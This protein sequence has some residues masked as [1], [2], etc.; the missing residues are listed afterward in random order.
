MKDI[1][2]KKELEEII[3]KLENGIDKFIIAG[4]Y[5]GLN[6]SSNYKE[7]LLNLK[8]DC[9]DFE[10]ETINLPDGRIVKM[11]KLLKQ[12]T[13]EAIEQ[14]IYIKMGSQ[15]RTNEDYILNSS[16]PYIIKSK[17]TKRNN[18]G[19]MPLKEVSIGCRIMAISN[20]TGKK[21]SPSLLKISGVYEVLKNKNKH[22]SISKAEEFLKENNMSIRKN[23]LIPILRELNAN[24]EK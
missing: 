5:Y 18:N 20:Y 7:Q 11:D 4:F 17:P 2:T 6:G 21:I 3:N 15:G 10:K 9:V 8:A 14:K 13:K 23:N 12:V 19:I 1:I 24:L 16:S 22:W